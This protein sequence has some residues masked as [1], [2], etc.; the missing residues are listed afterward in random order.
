[1]TEPSKVPL[2]MA[3]DA[4]LWQRWRNGER[5]DV[6]EFLGRF[7]DLE[8]TERVAVLLVDQRERWQVGERV[9]AESY[10]RRFPV[11]ESN[12]EAIVELAFGEFLLREQ[13]GEQPAL[14]EYIWR[15]PDHQV[16][17]RQQVVL[18][19]ALQGASAA[20]EASSIAVSGQTT[21]G[22]SA[23]DVPGVPMVPG[24]EVLEELGRGG[25]G[26]VYK[27]VQIGLNRLCALKMILYGG[28]AGPADLQRFHTEAEAIARLQHPNIV[29]VHEIGEHEG[30]PFFSWSIAR[31]EASTA[32]WPALP[33]RHPRRRRWCGLWPV[34]CK[35]RTRRTS[36]IAT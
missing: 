24:Y 33:C 26:V 17:L 34:P 19:R 5:V 30:K 14:E 28:Q 20:G 6:G 31:A 1:M 36:S 23:A 21:P 32:N 9:P 7:A 10:L 8:T 35:Q 2:E 27:A 25:M 4:Q 3:P 18:H 15:F 22:R 29:A 12:T 16:R 13:R 11:L